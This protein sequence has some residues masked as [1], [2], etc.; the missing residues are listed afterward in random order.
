MKIFIDVDGVI[1]LAKEGNGPMGLTLKDGVD[2]FIPWAVSNFDCYW[3]TAWAPSGRTSMIEGKLLPYLPEEAK[4][5]KIGVW[6]GLK[7]EA[8]KDGDFIWIDDNLLNDEKVY[9]EDNGWLS[10]FILVNSS[11]ASI[12]PVMQ[13]IKELCRMA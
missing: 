12:K 4:N 7:T 8:I 1:L 3:L 5:I 10:N 2:E 11:E 13:K 9:L 6:S